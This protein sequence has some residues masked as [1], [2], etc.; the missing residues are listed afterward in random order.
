[1]YY[2]VAQQLHNI[3]FR[4]SLLGNLTVKRSSGKTMIRF[5]QDLQFQLINYLLESTSISFDSNSQC[6]LCP[7]LINFMLNHLTF[8]VH[9]PGQIPSHL[10]ECSWGGIIILPVYTTPTSKIP[11][12][13][14]FESFVYHNRIPDSYLTPL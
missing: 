11:T 4:W 5:F 9:L 12:S 10:N 13:C 1:M 14:C 3:Q 2:C 8:L 7:L 6:A